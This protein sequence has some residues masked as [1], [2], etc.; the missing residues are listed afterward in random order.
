MAALLEL[1]GWVQHS[2]AALLMWGSRV[3]RMENEM[4]VY[5]GGSTGAGRL[6]GT[7]WCSS[8]NVGQKGLKNR[9]FNAFII[10]F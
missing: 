10:I 4:V 9:K 6:G 1:G 8:L 3:W 2:D 5:Y 7:L